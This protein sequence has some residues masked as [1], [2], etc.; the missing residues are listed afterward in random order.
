M[1]KRVT[2]EFQNVLLSRLLALLVDKGI[3]EFKYNGAVLT[4][5]LDTG[6]FLVAME[7][8]RFENN[9]FKVVSVFEVGLTALSG[10]WDNSFESEFRRT[11]KEYLPD[12]SFS[13]D[14]STGDTRTL[15]SIYRQA[16]LVLE[17]PNLSPSLHTKVV[18]LF[19]RR[20]IPTP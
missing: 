15:L 18:S 14:S 1:G 16:C 19:S 13:E 8:N 11:L 5:D 6:T 7:M 9:T 10:C 4:A 20:P 2:V 17:N 12:Q 3:A